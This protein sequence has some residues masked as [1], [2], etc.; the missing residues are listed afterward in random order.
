MQ[1]VTH[2]QREVILD[3]RFGMHVRAVATALRVRHA[4]RLA[5]GTEPGLADSRAEDEGVVVMQPGFGESRRRDDAAE[6]AGARVGG[7]AVDR[8]GITDRAG[9]HHDVSRL[10]GETRDLLRNHVLDA[11]THAL[12]PGV[13]LVFVGT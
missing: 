2:A 4:A 8:I 12:A 13:A 11:N 9:E 6:S 1:H 10:D 7:I 3:V 5:P